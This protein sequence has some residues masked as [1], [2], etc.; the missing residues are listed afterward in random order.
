MKKKTNTPK[1]TVRITNYQVETVTWITILK[2]IE[3]KK[4]QL[5]KDKTEPT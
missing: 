1:Y 5:K 2:I 4:K 3:Y